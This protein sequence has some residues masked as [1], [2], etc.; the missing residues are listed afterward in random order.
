MYTVKEIV[1]DPHLKKF[2]QNRD[3]RPNSMTNYVPALKNYSTYTELTLTELIDQAEQ[4]E[5][6]R[7]RMK[8]R[9]IKKHLQG[10]GI[11]KRGLKVVIMAI[12]YL[13]FT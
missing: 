12:L 6:D 13:K 8:N 2:L 5:E 1:N 3:L 11:L 9:Q 7:I 10:T 4:E